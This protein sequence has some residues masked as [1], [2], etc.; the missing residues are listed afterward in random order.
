MAPKYDEVFFRIVVF[1]AVFTACKD[2]LGLIR[3]KY[4]CTYI[5]TYI[6][7]YIPGTR[8][9]SFAYMWITSPFLVY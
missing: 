6:Y 5:H 2:E 8:A 4:I 1:Y 9:T 7:I 3:I